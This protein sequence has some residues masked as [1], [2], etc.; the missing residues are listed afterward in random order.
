MKEVERMSAVEIA[1]E[2]GWRTPDRRG[3][4]YL[5]LILSMMFAVLLLVSLLLF[6]AS[7][8]Y[9][10]T[11]ED[12]DQRVEKR[13]TSFYRDF[14]DS[15]M[16]DSFAELLR[17]DHI[18]NRITFRKKQALDVNVFDEVP[19]SGFFVNRHG[20]ERMSIEALKRGPATTTEPDP[21]GPWRILK[22]K[23]E[24]VSTGLFIEDNK[25]DQYLLKFDPKSNPEMATSAE[26]ISHKLF[27]AIGYH[28][29]EY[30]LVSFQ[31][32]IL[33]IDPN[34]TYYN[35]DGFK[36]KLTQEALWELL[37]RIPKMKGGVIR[38][39]AS[40][41]LQ[42][43]KGYMDFDGRRK[44]DPDDLIPHEDRRSIRALRVFGSWLNHYD[45]RKGNTLDAIEVEDG[46]T[47]VKHY[48]IDFGSTLGSAADHPKVPVA[49]YEHIVDWFKI[50][51]AIPRFKMVEEPWEKRWDELNRVIA[52]PSLGY[53][54]NFYFD[55]GEWKTQL[56]YDAFARLTAGDAFWAAKLIMSF[57]DDEIRAVVDTAE[58]SDSNDANVLSEVLIAR[59]DL[60]GRYWFSRA[61]PLDA[62]RLYHLEGNSYEISFEDLAVRYGFATEDETKYRFRMMASE[63]NGQGEASQY[64]EFQAP[65]LSFEAPHLSPE[66]QL[67]LLIQVKRGAGQ[68][69]SEPAL[70]VVLAPTGSEGLLQ[71]VEIDHGV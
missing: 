18:W 35:E 63:R 28:V 5:S 2:A 11:L 70:E 60:V 68:E 38:A 1:P 9:A 29:P 40:K 4:F 61:T 6:G 21:S 37:A 49:G 23:I 62:L 17:F 31:P 10:V 24:G 20:K 47:L 66:G 52:Y 59:R 44:S 39:S 69:W 32:D 42:E 26:I 3:L 58:F 36:K 34:A 45:L 7:R 14:F 16:Y 33:T 57:S 64:H 46:R 8:A 71:L 51:E 48:L 13:E 19:N 53:F 56:H 50:G 54:D 55:P 43:N 41:L 12:L 27:Y 22:G 65:S 25:G 67:A 30:Y 15:V